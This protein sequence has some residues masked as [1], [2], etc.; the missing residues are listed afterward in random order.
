MRV[1][2]VPYID[3]EFRSR[4]RVNWDLNIVRLHGNRYRFIT[5]ISSVTFLDGS[6]LPSAMFKTFVQLKGAA[7]HS[8]FDVRQGFISTNPISASAVEAEPIRV[9]R[10]NVN[11]EISIFFTAFSTQCAPAGVQKATLT[12]D[13]NNPYRAIASPDV[14]VCRI[15]P[16][17]KDC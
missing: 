16:T 8:S 5:P 6:P 10:G 4:V 3:G 13:P 12:L 2:E 14:T 1:H 7:V 17:P 11:G 9:E 15:P